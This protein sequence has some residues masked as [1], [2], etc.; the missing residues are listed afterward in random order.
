MWR[1]RCNITSLAPTNVDFCLTLCFCSYLFSRW[2]VARFNGSL[3]ILCEMSINV[4]RSHF[5][6]VPPPAL[7]LRSSWDIRF[8]LQEIDP[9]ANDNLGLSCARHPIVSWWRRPDR[10]SR[11]PL[12]RKDW[13]NSSH[14]P[15][16][17]SRYFLRGVVV[18]VQYYVLLLVALISILLYCPFSYP[19]AL[20][21]VYNV[22]FIVRSLS[23]AGA[24]IHYPVCDF[25]H[26]RACETH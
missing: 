13:A 14:M 12:P 7:Y 26:I 21:A 8:T 25:S 5:I 3:R 15:T 16:T 24:W 18:I 23:A 2:C 4:R 9:R 11:N 20:H 10:S 17:F 22:L 6:L 19:M 1:P